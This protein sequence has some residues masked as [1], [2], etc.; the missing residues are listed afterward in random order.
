LSGL[1]AFAGWVDRAN[2]CLGRWLCWLALFMVLVQVV[3]V[4]MR[5]VFGYGS[6]FVQETI[7]YAHG[8]MFLLAAG[9][10]LKH[11]GHVRVDIFY[12]EAS[13][14]TKAIIDIF[15]SLVFLIPICVLIFI[16]SFPYV[17]SSWA[18]LERSQESSGIPAV[19]VLKT[20]I[21]AFCAVL[22]L[23]ALA[24]TCR[25][26]VRLAGHEAPPRAEEVRGG[27]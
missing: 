4:L 10:T 13:P 18:I 16:V 1:A 25:C 19:F 11:D 17:R 23:Q 2:E 26:I 12:R 20:A 24:V 21:L 9:Y 22:I 8:F 5:Y 7:V 6:I 14:R 3:V 15:G 27:L